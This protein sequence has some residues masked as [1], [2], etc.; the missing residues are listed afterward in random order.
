MF[1]QQTSLPILW[2][3][4]VGNVKLDNPCISW[5]FYPILWQNIVVKQNMSHIA[6]NQISHQMHHVPVALL[7][8]G[9]PICKISDKLMQVYE[10]E[11]D[12]WRIFN[13]CLIF[14]LNCLPGRSRRLRRPP[15][16]TQFISPP[17]PTFTLPPPEE[18][19]GGGVSCFSLSFLP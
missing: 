5:I 16:S 11:D 1:I 7:R 17:S 19:A 9:R 12:I 4:L 15:T 13:L 2:I 8:I 14:D 6:Q 3:S 10:A 18:A